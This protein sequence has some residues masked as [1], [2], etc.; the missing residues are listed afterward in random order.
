MFLETAD[1]L[2]FSPTKVDRVLLVMEPKTNSEDGR[3]RGDWTE[4]LSPLYTADTETCPGQF[5]PC[6]LQLYRVASSLQMMDIRHIATGKLSVENSQL[7]PW[8]F[9]NSFNML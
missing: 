9:I 1:L 5:G 8:S 7:S 4:R 2:G 6:V 3:I